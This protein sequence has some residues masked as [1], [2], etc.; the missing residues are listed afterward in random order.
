MKFHVSLTLHVHQQG[1]SVMIT[2]SDIDAAKARWENAKLKF[3]VA[4]AGLGALKE[5]KIIIIDVLT[6]QGNTPQ[7]ALLAFDAYYAEH[8]DSCE[9]LKHE[10]DSLEKELSDLRAEYEQQKKKMHP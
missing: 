2:R 3:A 4:W 1:V 6:A 7:R 8:R 5:N 9:P 10:M